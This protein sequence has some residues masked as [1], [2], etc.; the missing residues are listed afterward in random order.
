MAWNK[1]SAL[2]TDNFYAPRVLC[3]PACTPEGRR[4]QADSSACVTG[5]PLSA[6]YP[7]GLVLC[8]QCVS[9]PMNQTR[10]LPAAAAQ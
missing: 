1:K 3:I 8:S 7:V 5:E 9:V 6:A 10:L 2:S 4:G